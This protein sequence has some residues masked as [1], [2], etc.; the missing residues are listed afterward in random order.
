MFEALRKL[1]PEQWFG[2]IL[3]IVL[4]GAALFVLW[5]YRILPTPDA[6]ATLM[7]NLIHPPAPEKP[8]P[9]KPKPQPKPRPIEPP[10]PQQLVAQVPVVLADEPV[11]ALPPD[12][13]VVI[14]APPLPPQPVMLSGELSV[15]CPERSPPSYPSLSMRMNEQG[16]VVLLV[17]LNT[18]GRVSSVQVK[19]ASGYRRLDEAAVNAVKGWR[20]KPA[21]R[22][23]IPVVT[24]ALQPFV[25]VLEGK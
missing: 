16:R 18:E 14:E 15:S 12:E 22:H 21:I 25:F 24:M 4:H 10:K 3:V 9:E 13:P 23:G 2:L 7:V 5:S 11:A 8:Q 1:T 17:E 19:T 6:A 20:C